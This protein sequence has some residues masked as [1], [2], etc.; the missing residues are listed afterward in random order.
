MKATVND[1]S[2]P[3]VRYSL[4]ALIWIF[5]V[6]SALP[7]LGSN[8][9]P[10]ML[11]ALQ[12]IPPALFA[13]L[14]GVQIYR[15]RGILVFTAICLAVGNIF[16]N[17]GIRTGFPF[18]SYYFTGVMGPKLFGVPI[19]MGPAY[20]AIGYTSWLLSHLILNNTDDVRP[21]R[22][23]ATPVLAAGIMVV[24]DLSAEPI[25]STIGHFW[26]WRRGGPYFGVPV[27]NFLG[28]FLTNYIIFQLFALYLSR[29]RS[30]SG[31][32]IPGVYWRL[33]VISYLVVIGASLGRLSF[34]MGTP[35]ISDAAGTQWNVTYVALTCALLSFFAMGTFAL[36]ASRRAS[37]SLAPAML[38]EKAASS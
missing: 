29:Q 10:S 12:I 30:G 36:L 23:V 37:R 15:P 1:G 32:R 38:A 20:L 5:G 3:W 4:I 17:L 18:G 33:A 14:H 6:A 35:P 24:W 7:V 16:E 8:L 27:S 19:L 31:S 22:V 9:P 28:W 21:G 34:L 26:I 11:V 25:W 2:V 13:L